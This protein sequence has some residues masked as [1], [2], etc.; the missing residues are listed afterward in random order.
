MRA[1]VR[2]VSRKEVELVRKTLKAN[3]GQHRRAGCEA[4]PPPVRPLQ[5]CRPDAAGDMK[6]S[7]WPSPWAGRAGKVE[8]T[9][10]LRTSC[11][12]APR[13]LVSVGMALGR[14]SGNPP[15]GASKGAEPQ[16]GNAPSRISLPDSARG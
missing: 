6:T 8:A 13:G 4:A 12:V 11:A 3:P 14:G 2:G 15:W 10:G 7:S 16:P 9:A 5:A 1:T